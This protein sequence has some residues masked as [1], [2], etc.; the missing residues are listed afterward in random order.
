[1]DQGRRDRRHAKRGAE[2]VITLTDRQFLVLLAVVLALPE[3]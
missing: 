1:M 2:Q 3:T